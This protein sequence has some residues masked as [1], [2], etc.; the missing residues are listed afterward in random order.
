MNIQTIKIK[1][2]TNCKI[3]RKVKLR[4][5]DGLVLW[6]C[7]VNMTIIIVGTYDMW[8]SIL[9]H[10][11]ILS[12]IIILL[13]IRVWLYFFDTATWRIFGVERIEINPLGVTYVKKK[14]LIK[15]R[16][17]IEMKNIVSITKS[18]IKERFFVPNTEDD[19]GRIQITFMRKLFCFRLLD[20]INIGS[21]FSDSEV[22]KLLSVYSNIK[23]IGDNGC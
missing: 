23:A 13:V 11:N 15:Q 19:K 3:E 21:Q 8:K 16:T 9:I 18:E 14:R 4:M 20:Q 10:M 5:G 17:F 12:V 6:G 7:F 22:D 1:M 2:E